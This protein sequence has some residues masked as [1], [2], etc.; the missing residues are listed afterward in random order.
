LWRSGF[1]RCGKVYSLRAEVGSADKHDGIITKWIMK[2]KNK[3]DE[4]EEI[5][6]EEEEIF[7]EEA[8]ELLKAG[9]GLEIGS[10][11]ELDWK[12]QSEKLILQHR[13]F[14]IIRGRAI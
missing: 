11:A 1:G 8:L 14:E 9:E 10:E 7:K 12:S 5:F 13:L 6:K 2:V 3:M 4:Q